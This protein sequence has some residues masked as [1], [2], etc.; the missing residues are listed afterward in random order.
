[1]DLHAEA[2]RLTLDVLAVRISAALSAAGVPHA[3]L[4]GPSTALWL[5][6]PPRTYRDVDMLVPASAAERVQRV[7]RDANLAFRA[8]GRVGEEAPHSLMLRSPDGWEVDIHVSLP[9]VPPHGDDAWLALA[10]HVEPLDLG[11]GIVPALDVPGRCLVTALH[12]LNNTGEQL[13]QPLEDLMRARATADAPAWEVAALIADRLRV[14]DL[15][16]AALG[17][18][19]PDRGCPS[20]ARARLYANQA[21]SSAFGLSRLAM[22][23]R[24]QLPGA[25]WRELFPSPGFMRFANPNAKDSTVGLVRA[26]LDRLLLIARELPSAIRALC[27]ARTTG[28]TG[29][30]RK[31]RD[32]GRDI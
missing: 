10:D 4:K 3:L 5:Y 32:A 11:V 1:M 15:M 14:G 28:A 12:A 30:D 19:E 6:D 22:L 7:L 25:L 9:T 24:R 13:R 16:G 27:I 17:L 26:Y 18:V 2:Q 29:K 31:A 23:P 21:P 8:A 20:S